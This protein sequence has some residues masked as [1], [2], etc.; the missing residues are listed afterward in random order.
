MGVHVQI[1]AFLQG[2]HD[3]HIDGLMKLFKIDA[4]AAARIKASLPCII[5]KNVDDNTASMY[6]LL[7]RQIGADVDLIPA[8]GADAPD[9]YQEP[10]V[11][12]DDSRA[13]EQTYDT[14][15]G[16]VE[17]LAPAPPHTAPDSST[18][19]Q[20]TYDDAPQSPPEYPI[21]P[22]EHFQQS[23]PADENMEVYGQ[24]TSSYDMSQTP[25]G[26]PCTPEDHYGDLEPE[27]GDAAAYPQEPISQEMSQ[28]PFDSPPEP[29]RNPL[30]ANV[31]TRDSADY[32]QDIAGDIQVMP[33]AAA[34]DPQESYRKKEET[35][36]SQASISLA[37]AAKEYKAPEEKR[38]FRPITQQATSY[39]QD[40]RYSRLSATVGR[41]NQPSS[42]GPIAQLLSG[43]VILGAAIALDDSCFLGNATPTSI[44][45][46]G[47]GFFN[48][49]DGAIR[50]VL[51]KVLVS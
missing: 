28:T 3:S 43:I 48:I 42:I 8:D 38:E 30:A 39:G 7:L 31:P 2:D 20:E 14:G 5:K 51:N 26:S 36:K 18:Y 4:T 44:F 11:E 13:T 15:A 49:A 29:E 47:M 40:K 17:G 23:Y 32:K 12:S 1:T 41:Q 16:D 27:T 34:T 19:A 21:A 25:E 9:A 22:D 24:E 6:V 10:W 35:Y 50:L 33:I 37:P 45:V 46:N